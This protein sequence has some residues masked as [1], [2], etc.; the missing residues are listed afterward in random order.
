MN[1][2][3]KNVCTACDFI[4]TV[5]YSCRSFS[6]D[7]DSTYT[8]YN[9]NKRA[10]KYHS[11][12]SLV[13]FSPIASRT[14]RDAA[15]DGNMHSQQPS[16]RGINSS[17]ACEHTLQR[18]LVCQI[19]CFTNSPPSVDPSNPPHS[20]DRIILGIFRDMTAVGEQQESLLLRE[21]ETDITMSRCM[22]IMTYLEQNLN[23]VRNEDI[24][25][26]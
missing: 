15:V 3:Y 5:E 2:L 10:L 13:L 20:G 11:Q 19:S 21:L 23:L 9:Q 14:P 8:H 1:G 17:E 18:T 4:P 24:S 7:I 6:K 12:V 16:R 25:H 22:Q 26:F